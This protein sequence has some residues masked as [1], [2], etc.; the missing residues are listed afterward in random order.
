M[1]PPDPPAPEVIA[2]GGYGPGLVTA[3]RL[4]VEQLLRLKDEPDSAALDLQAFA[5]AAFA[6]GAITYF[7]PYEAVHQHNLAALAGTA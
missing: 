2:A 6:T 3:T 4:Y 1:A 7:A 5:E